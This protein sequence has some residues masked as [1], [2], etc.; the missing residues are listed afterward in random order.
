MQK[1]ASTATAV[2]ECSFYHTH[3]TVSMVNG[4]IAWVVDSVVRLKSDHP[5]RILHIADLPE[6]IHMP[7]FDRTQWLG[8]LP[9][10]RA[11]PDPQSGF[12]TAV[13]R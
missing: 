7:E 8:P 13:F 9:N 2:P 5:H 6:E 1:T 3:P 4:G 12:A 11:G 10:P